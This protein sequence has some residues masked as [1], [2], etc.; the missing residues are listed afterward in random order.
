M[1]NS[2]LFNSIRQIWSKMKGLGVKDTQV[3][4]CK[5][6]GPDLHKGKQVDRE[7]NGYN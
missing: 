3:A 5:V 1:S 6:R 4:R 7:G 2:K